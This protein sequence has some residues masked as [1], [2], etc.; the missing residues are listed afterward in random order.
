MIGN[1]WE[2]TQDWWETQHTPEFKD[3]PVCAFQYLFIYHV[4]Q[5]ITTESHLNVA[6]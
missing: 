6:V 3:N 5:Y 1:V 2:W 4:S